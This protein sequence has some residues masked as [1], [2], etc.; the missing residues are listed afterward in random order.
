[1]LNPQRASSPGLLL[2]LLESESTGVSHSPAISGG[3]GRE[4]APGNLLSQGPG[5]LLAVP[6]GVSPASV[7][8]RVCE[9]SGLPCRNPHVKLRKKCRPSLPSSLSPMEKKRGQVTLSVIT[10]L[11]LP[12]AL[13]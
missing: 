11:I 1:M 6:P 5:C 12:R 3:S 8:T 7:G 2:W 10:I 4:L 13:V 9:A